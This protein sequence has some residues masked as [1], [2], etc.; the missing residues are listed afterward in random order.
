MQLLAILT[1]RVKQPT[2]D[3]IRAEMRLVEART[4]SQSGQYR[5]QR[6]VLDGRFVEAGRL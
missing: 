4:S 6:T 3:H 5:Q 2:A 1:C